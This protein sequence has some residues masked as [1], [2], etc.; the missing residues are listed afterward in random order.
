MS[1]DL[2]KADKRK[3]RQLAGIAWERELRQELLKIAAAIEE[4][5]NGSLSPFEV[6]DSIHI[7]HEGASRDLYRHYAD[8]HPWL[9]VC[10]AYC[11][12]VLTDEDLVD[13][14]DEVRNGIREFAASLAKL[15]AEA[16][17]SDEEGRENLEK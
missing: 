16:G 8:S 4:M 13:A 2:T 9:G 7:F 6:N 12:R 15:D 5:E 1:G 11:D 3:V 17:I 14:S 10:R